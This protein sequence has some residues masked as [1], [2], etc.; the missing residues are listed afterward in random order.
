VIDREL[1]LLKLRSII[2]N[3]EWAI[4]CANMETTRNGSWT[5][6]WYKDLRE[7]GHQVQKLIADIESDY[8]RDT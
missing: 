5:C 3:K 2:A 6:D 4:A 1:T 7:A 8:W